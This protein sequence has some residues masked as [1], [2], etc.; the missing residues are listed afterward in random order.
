MPAASDTQIVEGQFEDAPEEASGPRAGHAYI[1]EVPAD[2][3]TLLQWSSESESEDQD[4]IAE[5]EDA[6]EE[7]AF[8]TLRAEDEDWEI[9]ERGASHIQFVCSASS[10]HAHRLH[11]A[12][13]S[14]QATRRYTDRCCSG[15][16]VLREQKC[17]YG[18]TACGQSP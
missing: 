5:E 15:C 14:C 12:V 10:D 11:E 1:D 13:Q 4:E 7:A 9:A 18:L 2:E 17:H 8:Q 3:H 6:M 16:S